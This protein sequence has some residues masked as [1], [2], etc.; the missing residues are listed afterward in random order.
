[1]LKFIKFLHFILD[2]GTIIILIYLFG[3]SMN[4]DGRC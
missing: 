2:E 4:F 1:M 3:W